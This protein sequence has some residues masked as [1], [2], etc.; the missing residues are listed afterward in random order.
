M[1]QQLFP[2]QYKAS[3]LELVYR[4][5]TRPE[6]R[7]K[8]NGSKSAYELLF[9]SWDKD[10][11]ELVEQF[12]IILLD[13]RLNCLGI[14]EISTG[15]MSMCPV[16]MKLVFSTALLAKASKLIAAHNHPSGFPHP[17]KEDINLTR[18]MVE[19]GK[20]LSIGVQDHLIVTKYDYYSLADNGLMP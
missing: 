8:I 15:G 2:L 18:Q 10:R 19:A 12:K 3:E 17:S 4:N 5:E 16:D 9:N 1:Q 7:L 11:I 13:F 6:D 20:L 14:C